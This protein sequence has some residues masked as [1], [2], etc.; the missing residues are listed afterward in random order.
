MSDV[1]VEWSL[2][3]TLKTVTRTTVDFEEVITVVESTINAVVQPADKEKL[4]TDQIDWELDYLLVHSIS[5]LI[6]G[7]YIVYNGNDYKII[8]DGNYALYGFSEV[9]AEQT[10]RPAIVS[11]P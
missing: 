7:Q 1:L 2:P 8:S 6:N 3:Y 11:T 9:V 4:N 10:N 5:E